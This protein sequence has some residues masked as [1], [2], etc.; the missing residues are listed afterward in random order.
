MTLT[1]R[2]NSVILT[3]RFLDPQDWTHSEVNTLQTPSLYLQ[4]PDGR[5]AFTLSEG[6][7]A[8]PSQFA[9]TTLSYTLSTLGAVR[10]VLGMW[11][12]VGVHRVN[13]TNNTHTDVLMINRHVFEG[14]GENRVMVG[15]DEIFIYM[16]GVALPNFTSAADCAAW[17]SNLQSWG[18]PDPAQFPAG[19]RIDWGAYDVDHVLNGTAAANTLVGTVY[20]DLI[21]GYGGN[22]SLTGGAGNDTLN[23][24]TGAD[25][26]I[27]G[28]GDDVLAAGAPDT[29]VDSLVGGL[30]S[31]TADYSAVTVASGIMINLVTGQ[32]VNP[33]QVGV[34]RLVEIEN[35]IGGAGN[36]NITGTAGVNRLDG[37][38]GN[39]TMRG[40]AGNDTYVVNSLLDSVVEVAGAGVDQV[41]ARVTGYTLAAAV[42]NLTLDGLVRAGNGNALSNVLTGNAANN[43]LS[44]GDGAD[45]L[46][47]GAG[48]DSLLGGGGNDVLTGGLGA[49]TMLG[50]AGNDTYY[51]DALVDRVWETTVAG[52][53]VNAGGLDT[54]HTTVSISLASYAGVQFVENVIVDGYNAV[55]VS[56]NALA[57]QITAN[58]LNN[59]LN[60]GLGADTITT[61]LGSD[62]IVFN[63]AIGAGNVD[64]ITD[65]Y[66]YYDTIRLEDAIFTVLTP[67]A[68]AASAFVANEGG[69]AQDAGD[70]ILF[71]TATTGLYYDSNGTAAGGRVLIAYVAGS[72]LTAADFVV[73]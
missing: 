36:D 70:R 16:D 47:G 58:D 10:D 72:I 3:R 50:G 68:L 56:G 57:N 18:P 61:G 31:D 46:L 5:A 27:G 32:A 42:E 54:V 33:T 24:G 13:Y 35:V 62:T 51:V 49:D 30:G 34:D 73:I 12:I 44:G 15:F 26:L 7:Y 8:D 19:S 64:R 40:G 52:G 28:A 53:T 37:G 43:V 71:D 63:T 55:N 22:D 65:F 41:I 48:A 67:G 38:G 60:G 11:N 45:S 2:F 9:Q 59:V 25:T 14:T 20:N 29:A 39:D 69:V 66:A 21:N 6:G 17:A 4:T 1:Y 23:G